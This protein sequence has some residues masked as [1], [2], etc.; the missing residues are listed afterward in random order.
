MMMPLVA[1][2]VVAEVWRSSLRAAALAQARVRRRADAFLLASSSGQAGTTSWKRGAGSGM[3]GRSALQQVLRTRRAA[4]LLLG[5]LVLLAPLLLLLLQRWRVEPAGRTQQGGDEEE[6]RLLS[7]AYPRDDADEEAGAQ[8]DGRR[9]FMYDLPREFNLGVLGKCWGRAVPWLNFCPHALNQGL[10]RMLDLAMAASA[11]GGHGPSDSAPPPS[12]LQLASRF[13]APRKLHQGV[14]PG[15]RRRWDARAVRALI[16]REAEPNKEEASVRVVRAGGSWFGTDAY[17][18]EEMFHARMLQYPCLTTDPARASAFFLPFYA[19]L[20]ALE[21]LYGARRAQ[22]HLHGR[23]LVEYLERGA[24]A[25]LRRAWARHGGRDHFLVAGRTA[26]DFNRGEADAGAPDGWGTGL[27]RHPELQNVTFLV[28]ESRGWRPEEE[29]AVP[30]PTSFHPPVV[31]TRAQRKRA[32]REQQGQQQNLGKMELQEWVRKVRR[33]RRVSLFAYAGAPRPGLEHSIRAALSD[34]CLRANINNN[35][36]VGGGGG[37]DDT[38]SSSSSTATLQPP[39]LLRD[40]RFAPVCAGGA[41]TH[42]PAP[43]TAAFLRSHFCLQP[44]GD[45]ATRRSTF[46]AIVAGCIPVFFHPDSA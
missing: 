10:G 25:A 7:F 32:Q 30:Y 14:D 6:Y 23:A 38:I 11:G 45:T 16:L 9:I 20:A 24:P 42:N 21:Y 41:S 40:L 15:R 44:R 22:P 2:Q 3:G 26:W 43:A 29:Q 27:F 33:S 36:H 28:L 18:L 13:F 8:C 39:L 12:E 31:P 4:L 5:L 34:K 17:M 46:D 19:G 37:D 35:S 1:K